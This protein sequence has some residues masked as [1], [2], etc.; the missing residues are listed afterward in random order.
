MVTHCFS[1]KRLSNWAPL[2]LNEFLS[3]F[4]LHFGTIKNHFNDFLVELLDR[5]SKENNSLTYVSVCVLFTAFITNLRS[6]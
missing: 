1:L 4:R 6:S 5:D 3:N 2:Y